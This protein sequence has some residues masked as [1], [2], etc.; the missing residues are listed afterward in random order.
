M[1]HKDMTSHIRTCIKRYG[2]KA[3]VKAQ[4]VCGDSLISV[5]VPSYEAEF[6]ADEIYNFCMAAKSN[7]LTFVQGLEIIPEE[8]KLLT[9]K[10]QWNFIYHQ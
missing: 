9:G 5:S 6:T 2:I 4:K 7:N 10:K 8:Q 1:N 3:R